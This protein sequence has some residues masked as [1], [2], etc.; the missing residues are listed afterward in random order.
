MEMMDLRGETINEIHCQNTLD[1][2]ETEMP[3]L[4]CHMGDGVQL[5]EPSLCHRQF[6]D[7]GD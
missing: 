2:N 3:A 1:D 6:G 5:M 7:G 4:C